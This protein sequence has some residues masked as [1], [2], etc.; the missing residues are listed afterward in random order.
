M[1]G[2]ADFGPQTGHGQD[3]GDTDQTRNAGTLDRVLSGIVS[4]EGG[5]RPLGSPDLSSNVPAAIGRSEMDMRRCRSSRFQPVSRSGEIGLTPETVI[6]YGNPAMGAGPDAGSV[7]VPVT[8][9]RMSPT[10]RA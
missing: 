8:A 2:T 3:R 5:D 7:G 6:E 9:T 4:R 1:E 10:V